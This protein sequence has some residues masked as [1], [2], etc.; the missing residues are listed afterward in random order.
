VATFKVAA[1]RLSGNKLFQGKEYFL[2]V[3]QK[4]IAAQSNVEKL[5]DMK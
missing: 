3:I 1:L 2:S 4:I 5:Y